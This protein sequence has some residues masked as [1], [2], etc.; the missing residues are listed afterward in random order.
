ME[1]KRGSNSCKDGV[2]SRILDLDSFA[3]TFN[4]KFDKGKTA[5]PTITG[6]VLSILLFAL[7]LVYAV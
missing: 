1:K 2:Q 7:T 5:L 6:S 4:V 3:E